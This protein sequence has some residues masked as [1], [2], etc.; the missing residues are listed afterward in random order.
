[1]SVLRS[2]PEGATARLGRTG[3]PQIETATGGT[4]PIV[5]GPRQPGFNAIDLLHAALAACMAM[6]LRSAAH[7][8]GV[9]EALEHVAVS[10]AG[11]KSSAGPARI[12]RFDIT[13]T[14]AGA[15]SPDVRAEMTRMA[16][17]ELCTVSNT[18]TGGT[19]L[20]VRQGADAER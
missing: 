10:V 6:S 3:F 17:E 1:M 2:R 18:L 13:V 7:R 15:L 5:T 19:E 20:C 12:A 4:L 16:E 14:I 8:L 11:E 9:F